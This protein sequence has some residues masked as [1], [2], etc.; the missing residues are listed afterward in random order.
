MD[1]LLLDDPSILPSRPRGTPAKSHGR[2][3]PGLARGAA[4][5]P[6]GSM[7]TRILPP[8]VSWPD[9]ASNPGARAG[10]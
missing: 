3:R 8:G 6:T 4:S 7:R 5:P 2:C 9:R 10:L 1:R